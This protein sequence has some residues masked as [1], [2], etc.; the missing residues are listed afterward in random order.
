[1]LDLLAARFL[2]FLVPVQII[3]HEDINRCD[4]WEIMILAQMLFF[5]TNLITIHHTRQKEPVILFRC[6]IVNRKL[7]RKLILRHFLKALIIFAQHTDIQI[8]IPR[9]KSTMAHGTNQRPPFREVSN[10]IFF[11]DAVNLYKNL[12]LCP[13]RL[14]DCRRHVKSVTHLILIKFC[15]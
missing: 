14:L 5:K 15:G 1:M 9:H 8:I 2:L 10:I 13:P 3:H 11:T 12:K 4:I 6:I 7:S